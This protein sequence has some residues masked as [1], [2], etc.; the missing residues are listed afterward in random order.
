M[1]SSISESSLSTAYSKSDGLMSRV[2]PGGSGPYSPVSHF[3][4]SDIVRRSSVGTS[5]ITVLEE[6]GI[7]RGAARGD[8]RTSKTAAMPATTPA[9]SQSF[10][11]DLGSGGQ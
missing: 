2:I 10:K 6:D 3:R 1:T 4:I 8:H 11:R 9:T 7:E 5:C